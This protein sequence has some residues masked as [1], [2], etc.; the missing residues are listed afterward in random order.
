M[1]RYLNYYT[2]DGNVVW[3]DKPVNEEVT[4]F[5]DWLNWLLIDHPDF[6][7]FF[8]TMSTDVF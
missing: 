4:G 7:F 2:P 5:N 1:R 8:T 6:I 3:G